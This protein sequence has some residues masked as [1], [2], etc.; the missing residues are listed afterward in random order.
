MQFVPTQVNIGIFNIARTKVCREAVAKWMEFIGADEFVI[1]EDGAISDPALLVALAGKRCYMAFQKSLNP[2]LTR[3][4]SD[5]VDYFDNI[6]SSGHGSVLEHAVYTFAIENV[7]RV[8]TAEM[9]RHRA[10]WA[11]SEGSLRFIR[12]GQNIPYWLPTSFT[13]QPGD[14]DDI[15]RR[16]MASQQ[17][18]HLAFMEQEA[19]YRRLEEIWDINNPE[20]KFKEKKIVT[21]ALRR[22]VGLGVATGGVWSGNLRAIRHVLTMRC[23]EAAEEEMIHVFSRIVG[24]MR[25]MEPEIFGD[26]HQDDNGFWRPGYRKV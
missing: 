17:E 26:F 5:Y 13:V 24:M 10:G 15:M 14:S 8:F 23:E 3:V 21:S 4:R 20:K 19:R 7:S 18:M 2:N 16:K 6:L 12:F 11:I 9:N 1:P 22:I 25:D